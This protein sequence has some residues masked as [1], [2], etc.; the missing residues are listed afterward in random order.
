VIADPGAMVTIKVEN[1]KP[2]AV[3][4]APKDGVDIVTQ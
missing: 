2:R 3:V 4:I 1:G